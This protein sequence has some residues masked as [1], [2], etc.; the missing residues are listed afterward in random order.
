MPSF[1]KIILWLVF[2]IVVV[3]LGLGLERVYFLY[4]AEHPQVKWGVNFSQYYAQKKLD[5]GWKATY[6]AILDDLKVKR[7]RLVAY[8][9]LVEPQEHGQYDFADLD[10]QIE[11]AYKRNISVILVLG[12]R[13]PRWPECFAPDWLREMSKAGQKQVL[14]ELL[15]AEVEHFK[16]YDNI[17]TWQIENEPLLFWFG[18]CSRMSRGNLKEEVNLV[19]SLDTRPILLSAS[20]EFS[21]WLREAG[22]ADILGISIYRRVWSGFWFAKG[23]RSYPL[24]S[25]FYRWKRYYIK[26]F[27]DKL[28]VTEMQAEPWAPGQQ[29]LKDISF[30]EQDKS[31][32]FGQFESALNYAASTGIE[33]IYLWGAEWWWWRKLQGDARFWDK[34]K[35][36]ISS[37]Q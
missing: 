21:T 28:I 36:V 20:G 8:W 23:Y 22:L 17:E 32:S 37:G 27:V 12:Y 29:E 26:P 1:R 33:E 11:Q 3:A 18:Q 7:V 30:V 13:V 2:V 9:D 14:L 31:M 16:K 6:M 4:F 34:A 24:P 19:R 10:W 35:E 15:K 5:L 25:D